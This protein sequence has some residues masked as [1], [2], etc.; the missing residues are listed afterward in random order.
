MSARVIWLL[1]A[2]LKAKTIA[3]AISVGAQSFG[4]TNNN[5]SW[6]EQPDAS[7][8]T[9]HCISI[10]IRKKLCILSN[11]LKAINTCATLEVR[12]DSATAL[13]SREVSCGAIGFGTAGCLQMSRRRV[14]TA[15]TTSENLC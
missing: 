8:G 7:K 3:V 4:F 13:R 14:T 9:V 15:V 10:C 11:E 2:R 1:D 12:C 6:P 5:R